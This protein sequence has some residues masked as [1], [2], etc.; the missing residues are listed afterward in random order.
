V[1]KTVA[2]GGQEGLSLKSFELVITLSIHEPRC[3][4]LLSFCYITRL[5]SCLP[6]G[7]RSRRRTRII[8]GENTRQGTKTASAQPLGPTPFRTGPATSTWS[9]PPPPQRESASFIGQ[10]IIIIGAPISV[11]GGL[12]PSS[13]IPI[14]AWRPGRMGKRSK[15]FRLQ[16]M[17]GG[18]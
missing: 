4:L 8:Y 14:A 3:R 11:I 15:R 12:I 17:R 6:V 2:G 18:I 1:G 7:V 5:S 13:R 9:Q 10:Q 16:K